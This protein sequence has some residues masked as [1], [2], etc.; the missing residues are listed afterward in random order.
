[1]RK[2]RQR[3]TIK[4]YNHAVDIFQ[5]NKPK[6]KRPKTIWGSFL[7]QV[8]DNSGHHDII[9]VIIFYKAYHIVIRCYIFKAWSTIRSGHHAESRWV[10]YIYR[11][12]WHQNTTTTKPLSQTFV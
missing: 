2:Q 8:L 4:E 3:K 1:M 7:I 12:S 10:G 5:S 11:K 9:V 6:F